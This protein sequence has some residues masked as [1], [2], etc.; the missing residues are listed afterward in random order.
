MKKRG[1]I[2]LI[3]LVLLVLPFILAANHPTIEFVPPTPANGSTQTNTDI[4]VNLSTTDGGGDH[5]AFVDFDDNLVLWMRMD[6]VNSSG[7]P[8]DLSSYSNNGSLVGNAL[9]NSTGYWGNASHFDGDGDYVELNIIHF[10][11]HFLLKQL[12]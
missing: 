8:T 10:P 12:E 4:F 7:D 1:I 9:I 11:P 3:I 6:D 2:V 5:Y